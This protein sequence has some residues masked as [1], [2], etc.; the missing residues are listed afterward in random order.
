MRLIQT[1]TIIALVISCATS[2]PSSDS[3][4]ATIAKQVALADEAYE[5]GRFGTAASRYRQALLYARSQDDPRLIAPLL[6][7]LGTSLQQSHLCED[8]RV[9]FQEAFDLYNSIE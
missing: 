1:F 5:L 8:A 4:N 9:V 7:N 2:Q 6:H 3:T